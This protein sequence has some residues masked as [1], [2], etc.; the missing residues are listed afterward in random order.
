MPC[1]AKPSVTPRSLAMG[2]SKLTG[3]NSDAISTNTHRVMAKTPLQHARSWLCGI[4]RLNVDIINLSDAPLA[5]FR[6]AGGGRY[7]PE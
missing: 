2:V 7:S 3:I 1:P 5:K 6:Q 4:S